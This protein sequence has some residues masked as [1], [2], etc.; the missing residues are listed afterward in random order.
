MLARAEPPEG[1]ADADGEEEMLATGGPFEPELPQAAASSPH[2]SGPA[3]NTARRCV[4]A[5]SLHR[6]VTCRSLIGGQRFRRGFNSQ[7]L[8]NQTGADRAAQHPGHV[9]VLV[10]DDHAELSETVAVGLRRHE[11]AVD[12]PCGLCI[13]GCVGPSLMSIET[14]PV[15]VSLGDRGAAMSPTGAAFRCRAVVVGARR[16]T[17]R[18]V[19]LGGSAP[20]IGSPGSARF[21]RS[22]TVRW[23]A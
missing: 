2:A 19:C 9:P 3:I 7:R 23:R 18:P 16:C 5:S 22:A 12:G 1:V 8:T 6:T 11:V 20:R 15:I 21:A 10:I 14:R 13:A 17:Q 4:M